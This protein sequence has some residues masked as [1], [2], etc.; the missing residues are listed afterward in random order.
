MKKY[1]VTFLCF[2]FCLLFSQGVFAQDFSSLDS[3]LQLLEDLIRDTLTNT[4]EQQRLQ[5]A[6]K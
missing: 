3:D 4:E 6:V 5:I 2:I 1:A